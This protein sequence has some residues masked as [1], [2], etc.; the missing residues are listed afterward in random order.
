MKQQIDVIYDFKE[1]SL[2]IKN[3]YGLNLKYQNVSKV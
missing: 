3:L 1:K 2:V